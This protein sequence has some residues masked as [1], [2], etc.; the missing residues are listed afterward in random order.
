MLEHAIIA[1]A[2]PTLARLKVGSLFPL[3]DG[4]N[5]EADIAAMN[6]RLNGKGLY[7]AAF[8]ARND[9][10]LVYVYRAA[11]LAELLSRGDIGAF[12][13]R[14]G[15]TD[16]SVSGALARLSG[17]IGASEIFPH[18]IG[19]FLGYPLA[20]VE[21]FI[22]NN[23]R[24]CACCGY[25]KVYTDVYGAQ[26]AFDRCRKCERVYGRCFEKGISIEKLAVAS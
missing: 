23:G 26:R 9:R 12:L 21:A 13:G 17:R 18:E 7:I 14:F 10:T 2:A 25:W 5:A 8:R 16:L 22:L 15:Y 20:D 19:I 4:S 3:R 11:E 6:A 1:H 24:N